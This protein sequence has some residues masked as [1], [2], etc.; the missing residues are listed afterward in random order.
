MNEIPV[1]QSMKPQSSFIQ[2][3]RTWNRLWFLRL[4]AMVLLCSLGFFIP[5]AQAADTYTLTYNATGGAVTPST[6]PVTFGSAYGPLATPT[7]SGYTFA[8]WWST[9][10]SIRFNNPQGVAV[11]GNGNVYVADT[12]NH[13]IRKIMPDGVAT[14]VAG[15]PGISGSTDGIGNGARFNEPNGVAVDINGNLYVVDTGNH[16]IR[17]ITPA[18]VVT[19]IAGSPGVSG[20]TDGPGRFARFNSPR[21][22]AVDGNGNVYVVDQW[23]HTIRKISPAGDV[24][25]FA[26]SPGISGSADGNGNDARFDLPF[27]IAVD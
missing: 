27:C 18:G 16:T 26:G 23:N 5:L 11:D 10:N 22:L 9:G 14:I 13:T 15:S 25:T 19:T 8:G 2:S 1:R 21:G 20:S 3:T 6:Q 17:K 7:R 4:I 12:G 24:I